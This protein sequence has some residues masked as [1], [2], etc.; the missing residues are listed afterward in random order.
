MAKFNRVEQCSRFVA[1]LL[2]PYCRS[3][4]SAIS[5]DFGRL[6]PVEFQ[7]E[8][9]G[10]LLARGGQAGN[11]NILRHISASHKEPFSSSSTDTV[12]DS[13]SVLHG[14]STGRP[15]KTPGQEDRLLYHICVARTASSLRV[16]SAVSGRNP[17]IN[18]QISRQTVNRR[19]LSPGRRA[20]RPAK[21]APFDLSEKA[22]T[23]GMGRQH[24][25][26]QL[27]ASLTSCTFF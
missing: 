4:A 19:L 16:P 25:H 6:C 9:L 17:C 23:L 15:K 14:V 8:R 11:K 7:R 26:R 20:R 21:K 2:V 13:K 10:N 22:K 24:R 27:H 1:L 3:V 12:R 18:C 5:S